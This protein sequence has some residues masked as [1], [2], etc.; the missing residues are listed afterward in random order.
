MCGSRGDGN[1]DYSVLSSNQSDGGPNSEVVS[2]KIFVRAYTHEVL[3]ECD[4][5]EWSTCVIERA[6]QSLPRK[7]AITSKF[8]LF[9]RVTICGEGGVHG[10]HVKYDFARS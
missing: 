7:T 5:R 4:R 6:G 9:S 1:S 8:S 2:G 3:G 10:M